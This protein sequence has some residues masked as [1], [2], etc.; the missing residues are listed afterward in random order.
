MQV[1]A[2]HPAHI[3]HLHA[4]RIYAHAAAQM[5]QLPCPTVQLINDCKHKLEVLVLNKKSNELDQ[6]MTEHYG[7]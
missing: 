3:S 1:H 5:Q 7:F 4:C 6:T 2:L